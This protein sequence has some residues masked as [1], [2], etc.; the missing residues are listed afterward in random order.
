MNLITPTEA[1]FSTR[2]LS[3]LTTVLQRYI[4]QN[5]FKGLITLLAR[6]GQ[7]FHLECLGLMD[8]EA[9]KV[10]QSDAIFRIYSMSKP[11][12]SVALMMLYEEGRFQLN[13]PVSK[14][15]PEFKDLKVLVDSG[16]SALKLVATEREM[17]IRDL[18]THT[19]GLSYS[20]FYVPILP[21]H[22]ATGAGQRHFQDFDLSGS[23]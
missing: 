20:L 2:R 4:D 14:Y 16:Q 3:R 5:I 7:V 6:R 21:V 8:A 19:S 1:G 15:I 9:K 17:T 18:L 13:E 22:A 12:T 23:C 11:I 10:M